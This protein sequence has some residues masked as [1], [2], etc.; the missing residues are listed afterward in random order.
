MVFR[1]CFCALLH[2]LNPPC[3]QSLVNPIVRKDTLQIGNLLH[4]CSMQVQTIVLIVE[5]D[6]HNNSP[7]VKSIQACKE[8]YK[9][10]KKVGE[11]TRGHAARHWHFARPLLLQVLNKGFIN[12]WEKL[13]LQT[14]LSESHPIWM[15]C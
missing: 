7:D 3:G 6:E 8:V 4:I 12:L 11:G 10:R 14:S 13:R 5:E 2:L 9:Q 15:V 1:Q